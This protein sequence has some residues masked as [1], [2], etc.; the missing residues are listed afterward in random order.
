MKQ[1]RWRYKERFEEEYPDDLAT[2]D[3]DSYEQ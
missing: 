3:E 2:F 1:S